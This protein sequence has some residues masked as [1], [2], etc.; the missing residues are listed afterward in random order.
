MRAAASAGGHAASLAR[1]HAPFTSSSA[2][3]NGCDPQRGTNT[4]RSPVLVS[5]AV[6]V[7]TVVP[8]DATAAMI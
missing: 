7:S 2:N 4:A 8:R 3:N 5:R 1:V 6:T